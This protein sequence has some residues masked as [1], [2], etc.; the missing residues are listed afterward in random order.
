MNFIDRIS[1]RI[2]DIKKA[3]R[4]RILKEPEGIDFC[5]NDYLGMAGRKETVKY[6]KEGTTIYGGGS[7][8]SRLIRG[9]RDIFPQ[10]EDTFSRWVNSESTLF[11][12]NGFLANIGL[13]DAIKDKSTKI[14]CDRLNHASILDGIRLSNCDTRYY[15]HLDMNHL[16]DLLKKS[17][18]DDEKIIISETIF[19]M[20]GDTAKI[21]E[22]IRLKKTYN[23][24]LILD[25][26]HA[27]GVYGREGAGLSNTGSIDP[28]NDIDF[29][30]FTGGKS[31]GLEG[32]F[33]S[34]SQTCKDFLI[35]TL[36]SFIFTTAPLP[37]IAYALDKLIPIIRNMNSERKLIYKLSDKLR[38][39]FKENNYSTGNSSTHIIPVILNDELITMNLASKLQANGYDIRGIRPPTVKES[40]LRINVSANIEETQIHSLCSK[41]LELV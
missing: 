18:L 30:I 21:E 29:R 4:F 16:E 1:R 32:A 26:A 12:A 23:C 37:A 11:L 25:E 28:Y 20:D 9:H 2:I 34:C 19:S 8:A 24:I 3:N 17:S 7:T 15:R 22:L 33:I 6:L 38:L 36:R 31:L 14:F 35:N 10:L 40:R 39:F 13:L 27:L 5:S 41:F